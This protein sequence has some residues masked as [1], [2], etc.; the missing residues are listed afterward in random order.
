MKNVGINL[1]VVGFEG[2]D[3]IVKGVSQLLSSLLSIVDGL[4]ITSIATVRGE[5]VVL[6]LAN[7][8]SL[9]KALAYIEPRALNFSDYGAV[10]SADIKL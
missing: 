10:L 1:T 7:I 6:H 8:Q 5:A 2:S 9:S 3:L 4:D